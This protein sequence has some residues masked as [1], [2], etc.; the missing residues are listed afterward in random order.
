[1]L[2][3]DDFTLV[4]VDESYQ[5][6]N[7][8]SSGAVYVRGD[9]APIPMPLGNQRQ[10]VYGDVTLDRQTC[11]MAAGKANDRSFTRYPDNLQRRF[12][13]VAAVTYNAAYHNAVEGGGIGEHP[14]RCRGDIQRRVPQLWARQATSGK[15]RRFRQTGVPAAVFT[16]FESGR[17]AVAHS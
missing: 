8:F 15:E 1:M 9:T 14:G 13:R 2:E 7:I 11:Y 6:S 4:M 16:V 3:N 17:V 10:T 5:N 12:G